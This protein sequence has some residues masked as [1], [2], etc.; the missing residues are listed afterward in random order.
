MKKGEVKIISKIVCAVASSMP[1]VHS[2]E[3]YRH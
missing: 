3:A 2:E 1:I